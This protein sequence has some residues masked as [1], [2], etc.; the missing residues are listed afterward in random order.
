[1]HSSSIVFNVSNNGPSLM[2]FRNYFGGASTDRNQNALLRDFN[3][4]LQQNKQPLAKLSPEQRHMMIAMEQLLDTSLQPPI[5][6]PHSAQA[7]SQTHQPQSQIIRTANLSMSLESFLMIIGGLPGESKDILVKQSMVRMLDLVYS[8]DDLQMY[9]KPIY[10]LYHLLDGARYDLVTRSEVRPLLIQAVS[11][12]RF[13]AHGKEYVK[14]IGDAETI[15]ATSFQALF[16]SLVE[17]SIRLEHDRVYDITK[18]SYYA[19]MLELELEMKWKKANGPD[20]RYNPQAVVSQY[21]SE[22]SFQYC[23]WALSRV[24]T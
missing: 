15:N 4:L 6:Q 23:A 3:D 9:G 1:L 17:V 21:S 16:Y 14:M 22:I 18:R 10:R 8:T 13:S 5:S 24:W 19:G 11:Q 12:C 20:D 2:R 7:S